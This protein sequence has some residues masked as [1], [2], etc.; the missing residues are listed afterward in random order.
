[1]SAHDN[2]TRGFVKFCSFALILLLTEE[3]VSFYEESI[4]IQNSHD[5]YEAFR[6]PGFCRFVAGG[7]LIHI[8]VAAQS[9]AI[10]WEMYKRTHSSLALG[11][12]G[13]AQALPMIL[14][15]LPAGYLADVYDRRRIMS[16]GLFGTTLTS[17]ALA[18]FSLRQGSVPIMYV[19]LVLDAAFHRIA[20]PSSTALFPQLVPEKALEN[21]IKWRTSFFHIA[22]VIGPAIGGF[23]VSLWLPSAYLFSA[24]TTMLFLLFLRTL[25]IRKEAR[26]EPGRMASHVLEGIRFVWQQKV[27]LGA[28]SMDLF[29]V[30]LG[31]AV[32]LLPIFASDILRSCPFGMS[33]E[34]A[35]GWLR[36]APALGAVV[37]A[38]L[39]TYRPPIRRAGRAMFLAVAAYGLATIGFGLSRYFWLSCGMLFLTGFFD[40][41][42]VVIRHT[43]VQLRTPNPMRGR[44]SAVNSLFIG[45]SNELGG[46]EAGLVARAFGPVVS[47]V[48]GGLGTLLVVAGWARVF[49]E[50]LRFG[51]LNAVEPNPEEDHSA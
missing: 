42:S 46:F 33:P 13:L 2:G 34:Q 40:N 37:M 21:A 51:R 41:I 25:S 15:T 22:S 3:A 17:L 32:Y 1:M 27:L 35:L 48:S 47:V 6:F 10:G 5:P 31:G 19:L 23:L 28:I 36:S 50:L 16:I 11:L 39:L 14:L 12:V 26:A 4:V 43:L 18:V 30:L 20:G 24:A 7:L 8:G 9:V 44:V 29:A 38:A 45:S 49:P